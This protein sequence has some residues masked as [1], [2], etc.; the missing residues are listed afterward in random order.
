M[1]IPAASAPSATRLHHGVLL[2]AEPSQTSDAP[3]DVGAAGVC[4]EHT[5]VALSALL[6]PS[7]S[8]CGCSV[9]TSMA[10]A[11]REPKFLGEAECEARSPRSTESVWLC[12]AST[13]SAAH[14]A[15]SISFWRCA[16]ESCSAACALSASPPRFS[17]CRSASSHLSCA[18]NFSCSAFL[19][20]CCSEITVAWTAAFFFRSRWISSLALSTSASSS[21][22]RWLSC[23]AAAWSS[24]DMSSSWRSRS[25]S[26]RLLAISES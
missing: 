16:S 17:S 24:L 5:L 25:T 7:P 13:V 21:M 8:H 4:C 10:G 3:R 20:S 1:G 9:E 26:A 23:S 11:S 14:Q 12:F 19:R 6:A 18:C 2:S 15:S 22:R